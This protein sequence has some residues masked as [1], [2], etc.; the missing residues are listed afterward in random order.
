MKKLLAVLCTL[1]LTIGISAIGCSD[2]DD[3]SS[4]GACDEVIDAITTAFNDACA[5]YEDCTSCSDDA[6]DQAMESQGAAECDEDAAKACLDDQSACGID[7]I[8]TGIKAACDAEAAA[9]K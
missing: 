2:D 8:A 3:S 5:D 1:M 7:M 4:K 6:L 9:G